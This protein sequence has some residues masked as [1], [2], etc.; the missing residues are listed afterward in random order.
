MQTQDYLIVYLFLLGNVANFIQYCKLR[1]LSE[2]EAD[3]IIDELEELTN[4]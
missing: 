2:F 3:R 1:G 4:G